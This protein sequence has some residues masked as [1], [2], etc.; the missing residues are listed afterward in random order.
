MAKVVRKSEA[1][2]EQAGI[3]RKESHKEK[4]VTSITKKLA[5]EEAKKLRLEERRAKKQHE[6][7]EEAAKWLNVKLVE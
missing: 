5:E 4:N 2:K 1:E 6:E 3:A 7:D